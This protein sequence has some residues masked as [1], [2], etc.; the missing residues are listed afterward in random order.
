MSAGPHF[1]PF[2]KTHGGPTDE[3]RHV[4]DLGNV[5]A[6]GGVAKVDISDKQISLAG[7]LR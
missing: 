3:E 4:G 5:T 7:N 1:N 6:E 2:G